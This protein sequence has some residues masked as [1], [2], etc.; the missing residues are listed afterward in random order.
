MRRASLSL[1]CSLMKL[2]QSRFGVCR[3]EHQD[4]RMHEWVCMKV[5]RQMKAV[6]LLRLTKAQ[7]AM[8]HTSS[9]WH[10]RLSPTQNWYTRLH[11][12]RN[13]LVPF[14]NLSPIHHDPPHAP[15]PPNTACS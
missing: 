14:L 12:K 5:C 9:T 8:G 11:F 3:L 4:V 7:C 13:L 1:G 6:P 15:T 10:T 2:L